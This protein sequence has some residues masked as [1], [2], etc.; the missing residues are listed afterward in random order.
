VLS[1]E[2]GNLN[3]FVNTLFGQSFRGRNLHHHAVMDSS[4]AMG[5]NTIGSG[6]S[7]RVDIFGSA[8][9]SNIYGSTGDT[10]LV[11]PRM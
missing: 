11:L 2:R 6:T 8:R 7:S 9:M 1:Q 4:P 3:R 5:V 10:L